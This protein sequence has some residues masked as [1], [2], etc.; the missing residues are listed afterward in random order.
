MAELIIPTVPLNTGHEMPRLG[1]GTWPLTGRAATD[2]VLSAIGTGY[3]LID[4]AQAY[5][6]E[7]AVGQAVKEASVSRAELFITTK[8]TGRYQGKGLVRQGVEASLTTLGLDY[9][10]LFLIHW[11]DPALGL[12]VETY[13]SLLELA[14]EGLIRSIGV[15][16]F[17][18]PYLAELAKAT[19]V[20][21]AVDQLQVSPTIARYQ[22][23]ESIIPSSTIVQAWSPLERNS[24]ILDNPV[25]VAIARRHKVTA[26]Q[27]V[28]RWLMDRGL[29]TV[30]HTATPS[31]QREN[32]DIFNFHL[33]AEEVGQIYHLDGKTEGSLDP[34][35]FQD[36]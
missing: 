32:A 13:V 10:D 28:L 33:D 5:G 16:N 3:R 18:P 19:T 20:P 25:I 15:S 9:V 2:A 11:P 34:D 31:R 24:G 36:F 4:T 6:N 35:T 23:V 12:Y 26:G 29:T 30:P 14:G 22:T 1:Y 21:P 8:L 27:V 17:T 7:D